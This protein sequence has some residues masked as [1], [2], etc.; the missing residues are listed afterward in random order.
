MASPTKADEIALRIEEAIASG[1]I[2]AETVLRQGRLAEQ[3]GV[4]RTPIREALRLLAAEGLVAFAPNRGVRVRGTGSNELTEA[5]RIRAEL[6]GL[7][8]EL[9]DPPPDRRGA[10]A[11]ARCG[12]EDAELTHRL[13]DG[14]SASHRATL[15]VE[16]L[17]A[18]D[19][20]HAAVVR[21]AGAPLLARLLELV[22]RQFSGQ[23]LWSTHGTGTALGRIVDP[24]S[25]STGSSG[26][27][28]PPARAKRRAGSWS[29]MSSVPAKSSRNSCVKS[30]QTIKRDPKSPRRASIAHCTPQ[31][32]S[33]IRC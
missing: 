7:A 3:F 33:Q 6:E 13:V 25:P 32:G 9:R 28:W 24:G 15:A 5:F 10:R 17:R 26:R 27:R 8:V 21:A 29:G 30:V 19:D 12:A 18:N 23:A 1:A 2:P 14:V 16:W 4:S 20:F 31:T 11:D 22:R